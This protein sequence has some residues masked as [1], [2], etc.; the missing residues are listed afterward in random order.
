MV[1]L[2]ANEI[3]GNWATLLLPLDDDESINFKQLEDEID[4][5]IAHGVNGIYSN[6]TA[7]EFYNQT[8]D[9]FD[10]INEIL[11]TKCNAAFMPFQIGCSHMSPKISLER[12]KR[13]KLLKPSAIQVILPDWFVPSQAEIIHFLTRLAEEADP[14]RLVLYNPPHAK[15]K[16][17]P[18][19]FADILLAGIPLAGCKVSG[20]DEKWYREMSEL[21]VPFS[22][23]VPGHQLAT[24]ISQGAHGT[25]SNVA[26]LHPAFAQNWYNDMVNKTGDP[27]E[28]QSRI[29]QFMQQCMV[30]Y[31]RDQA[32]ANQ[33]VDKFMAAVGG[34][35]PISTRLRWP[36]RWIPE[37]EIHVVKQR[38]AELL[39]EVF[40]QR[41][42]KNQ[43]TKP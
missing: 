33:A 23:F 4:T 14:I 27:F 2:K 40:M 28:M 42:T 8:E 13:A 6:G 31:I 36:Y 22:V 12:L 1:P 19:D 18:S 10:Q 24:G 9:E 39:P 25:Y 35:T 3:Y 11:A 34:W 21:P 15:T 43:N 29:Q 32:Y 7:G 17:L 20:G 41:S 16:L 38:C 30:P 37:E 26:C 5:L